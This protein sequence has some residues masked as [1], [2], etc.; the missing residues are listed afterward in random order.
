MF[1]IGLP[2]LI[3]ILIV[4]LLVV[5]PKKLPDLA[6]SLGKALHDVKSMTEDVKQTFVEDIDLEANPDNDEGKTA[7]KP[8]SG[9][10]APKKV[11]KTEL[12]T[13][14]HSPEKITSDPYGNLRG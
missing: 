13:A 12:D 11:E 7:R 10:K 5:G 2:E 9:P 1:G 4:A 14:D 6:R 8:D 3:L